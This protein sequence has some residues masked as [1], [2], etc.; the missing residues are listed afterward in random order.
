MT[1][2]T[3]LYYRMIYLSP[4][5]PTT[6]RPRDAMDVELVFAPSTRVAPFKLPV[7]A[8]CEGAVEV[9]LKSTP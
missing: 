1:Y 8:K 2:S 4:S 6:L 7:F 9:N 3:I 5:H